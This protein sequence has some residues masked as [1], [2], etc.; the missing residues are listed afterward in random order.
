MARVERSSFPARLLCCGLA[1][2]AIVCA[3]GVRDARGQSVPK[4]TA[5]VNDFAHVIDAEST[6][7]LDDRIRALHDTTG[8]TLI[9]ATVETY[10]PFGSIEEYATRMFEVAGIGKKGENNG[11]LILVAVNDRRVRIEVGYGLEEFITDGF[12]GDTIR[13]AMLP[14]FR[15]RQYGQGVLAAATRIVRRL[16]DARGKEIPNLPKRQP[17]VRVGP[18]NGV[19]ALGV[20]FFV[21]MAL[22]FGG[23]GIIGGLMRAFGSGFGGRRGP[24]GPW[25]G[26]SGGVGGFGGGFGGGGFGGGGG[27]F[28]GFGG[29]SSGG[30]GASGGW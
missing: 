28:G 6:R 26:W 10:Q 12:S 11:V 20:I 9:V 4:L 29:G 7:T 8:D 3:A 19:S 13:S 22:L 1:A 16:G 30:G 15:N 23:G 25:S 18:A 24:R 2:L 17:S 21:L 5:P 14:A 27:G